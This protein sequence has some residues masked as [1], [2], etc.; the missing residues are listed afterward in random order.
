MT[1]LKLRILCG[2]LAGLLLTGCSLFKGD[3]NTDPDA[4]NPNVTA[5]ATE[6]PTLDP[7]A[8]PEGDP[9][10]AQDPSGSPSG[11]PADA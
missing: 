5:E 10:E 4:G 1:R 6:D 3:N 8:P 11:E 7:I 9:T 2:I